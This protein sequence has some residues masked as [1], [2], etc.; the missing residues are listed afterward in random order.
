M[1]ASSTIAASSAFS[2]ANCSI[3]T[4]KISGGSDNVTPLGMKPN[5]R[6]SF[7][8]LRAKVKAQAPEKHMNDYIYRQNFAI[9]SFEIGPN[10]MATIGAMLN[11][12]QATIANHIRYAGL[13]G[14]GFGSTPEMSK[15]NLIW[16]LAKMQV[17]VDRYPF[18][19]DVVQIDNWFAGASVKNGIANHWL[20]RDANTVETLAQANSVWIMMNRKTRKVSKFP[21]EVRNETAPIT[22]DY[23]ISDDIKLSKLHANTADYV[24]TGLTAHWSDLD[25]NHHVN[26]AKYIGWILENVPTLILNGHEVC[27]LALEFRRECGEGDVLKSLTTVFENG[28]NVE[29]QHMLQLENGNEVMRGRTKWRPGYEGKN[30]IEATFFWTSYKYVG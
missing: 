6:P 25:V 29:C 15:R 30:Q 21:E 10:R 19:G 9:R 20:L 1:V 5:M 18:W 12:L 22:M 14:D 3:T 23:C 24:Q 2:P 13:L 27:D 8:G 28:G 26:F 16:V 7:R 11:H 4:T 17:L